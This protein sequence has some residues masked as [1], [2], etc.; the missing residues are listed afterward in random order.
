[1]KWLTAMCQSGLSE[2][3]LK[4]NITLLPFIQLK[5]DESEQF[6]T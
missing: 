1:M 6:I 5:L 4:Q 2:G 3:N